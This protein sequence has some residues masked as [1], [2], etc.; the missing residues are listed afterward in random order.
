VSVAVDV[1][2]RA[3]E[4][5]SAA[6]GVDF[7]AFCEL[8]SGVPAAV[9]VVTARN[10]DGLA[11]GTTVSAFCSLSLNPPLVMVALN[12]SSDLLPFIEGQGRFGINVLAGGQ[13]EVGT[14]C[15]KK[16][17]DKL[18]GTS[19]R[20]DSGL[21]RIDGSAAWLAC[22]VQDILAG[23]DHVMVVGLVTACEPGEAEPLV[24]HRRNFWTLPNGEGRQP[25]I[26]AGRALS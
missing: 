16:G 12:R 4:T 7:D 20:Y 1:D 2:T 10:G 18:T 21:P 19:W 3:R 17:P 24:Y 13:E 9:T 22:D 11:H 23:G 5:A 8:F 25:S 26:A 14:A 15:A 6:N